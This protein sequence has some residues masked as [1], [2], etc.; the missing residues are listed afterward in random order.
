ML[1]QN[2]KGYN[3]VDLPAE[4]VCANMKIKL[5]CDD[6]KIHNK[7]VK[8]WLINCNVNILQWLPRS[9]DLNPIENVKKIIEGLVYDRKPCY[10]RQDLIL[11]F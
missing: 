5:F 8:E 2:F 6:S 1:E 7:A 10:A 9:L 3:H 4:T 11:P